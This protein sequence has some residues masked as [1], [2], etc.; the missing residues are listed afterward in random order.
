MTQPGDRLVRPAV[1]PAL[2]LVVWL[3][4]FTAIVLRAGAGARLDLRST[5][6]IRHE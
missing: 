5:S 6:A 1:I 2:L 4:G 3:G